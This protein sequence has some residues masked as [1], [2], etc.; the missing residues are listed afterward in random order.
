MRNNSEK[1]APRA[2]LA[3]V[4]TINQSTFSLQDVKERIQNRIPEQEKSITFLSRRATITMNL[5]KLSQNPKIRNNLRKTA[6][7]L[8]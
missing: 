2:L 4:E 8:C 3:H 1:A 7:S 6:D 5:T